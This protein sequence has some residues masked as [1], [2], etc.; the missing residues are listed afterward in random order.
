MTL[1][2]NCNQGAK[3]D[4]LAKNQDQ[5]KKMVT[6]VKADLDEHREAQ[7]QLEIDKEKRRAVQKSHEEEL[8]RQLNSMSCDMKEL[9]ELNKEFKDFKTA[10]RVGKTIGFGVAAFI[11]I[12]GIITGGVIAVKEWIK[13]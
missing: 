1:T 6:A 3:F 2:H 12:V 11:G 5:I 7:Q 9:L 4:E 10:W 13:R 8:T